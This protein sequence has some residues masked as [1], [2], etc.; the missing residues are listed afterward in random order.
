MTA[1]RIN[2]LPRDRQRALAREYLFRAATVALALLAALVVVHGVLLFPTY[3]SVLQETSERS[4]ELAARQAALNAANQGE[5]GARINAL[6]ATAKK[7]SELGER[8][9][10][11]SALALVLAVPRQGIALSA[12]TFSPAAAK[13]EAR[14]IV[15]GNAPSRDALRRY[16]ESLAALPFVSK[17]DLPI[18]AYAQESDIEFAIT[19]TGTFLP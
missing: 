16:R 1:D 5:V 8:S 18:S 3:L 7:L 9:T 10:A 14:M 19:L 2:L 11:S 17:A 15:S 6:T 13:D 12:F 4:H